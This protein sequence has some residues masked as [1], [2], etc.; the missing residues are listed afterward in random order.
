MSLRSV[1][2]AAVTVI[3]PEPLNATPFIVC[4]VCNAVAV[5][6][7]PLSEPV[8]GL[9]NVSVPVKVLLSASAVDDA[10]VTAILL[11]PLNAT[12]LM[13][14]AAAR[15]V[16]VLA[17]PVTE[18]TIGLVAVRLVIVAVVAVRLAIVAVA[19]LITLLRRLVRFANVAANPA[20]VDVALTLVDDAMSVATE[21][22]CEVK[23]PCRLPET[24]ALAAG[25]M[26]LRG[27]ISA[28][29]PTV[30]PR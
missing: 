3:L 28:S 29:V 22:F 20:D 2:D 14:R 1:D 12:P 24:Y 27:V 30:T 7:L 26:S 8:T 15:V 25:V 6:A 9:V 10:A 17:L 13:V 16:A 4:A 23:S 11:E 5:F 18:P 21:P 19:A